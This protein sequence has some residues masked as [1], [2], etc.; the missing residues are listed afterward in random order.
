MIHATTPRMTLVGELLLSVIRR[1]LPMGLEESGAGDY[2]AQRLARGETFPPYA[3]LIARAILDHKTDASAVIEIGAGLGE[4]P[5]LLAAEGFETWAV[6]RSE[7]RFEASRE[8]H[9]KLAEVDDD[10]VDRAHILCGEFPCPIT[11]TSPATSIMIST[12]L[13]FDATVEHETRLVDAMLG[14]RH[15]IVD[16]SRL[17]RYRS[18]PQAWAPVERRFLDAGFRVRRVLYEYVKPTDGGKVIWY[19]K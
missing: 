15:V 3:Q 2:Y 16:V 19:E 8:L 7:A 9:A 4:L 1:R 5:F 12:G 18:S 11:G 10:F 6:E 14:Y 13:V 17:V